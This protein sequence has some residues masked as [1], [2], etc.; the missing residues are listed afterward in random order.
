MDQG[1]TLAD[2]G[3]AKLLPQFME[4]GDVTGRAWHGTQIGGQVAWTRVSPWRITA[5]P[6]CCPNSWKRE[7]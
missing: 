4:T 1:F 2:Y 7:M 3:D 6:S 5:T